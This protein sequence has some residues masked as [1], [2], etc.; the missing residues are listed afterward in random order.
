[1]RARAV[2]GRHHA[3]TTHNAFHTP[4]CRSCA[5]CDCEPTRR[6]EPVRTRSRL[7]SLLQ[8]LRCEHARPCGKIPT[9][10]RLQELRKLRPRT[11]PARRTCQNAVATHVAPTAAS[12][13]PRKP[14]RQS[15]DAHPTAGAAQAATAP[16]PVAANLSERGRDSRRSYSRCDATTQDHAAKFRRTHDCRSCAS[17]DHEPTRRGEPVRTRS[18]LAS[19]LQS[20]RC[21]RVNPCGKIPTHIRLQELRKLRPRTNPSRRT[22]QNVVATHVA[23]T[24][25]AMRPRKTMRQNS[26]AHPTVGAA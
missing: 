1:M 2:S 13:R 25:A 15:S 10:I 4:N 22:C 12:M 21:G 19:L 3:Q 11:N 20:L 24:V 7:T 16:P 26:D 18:R 23:P 6:G 8:S 9:H 17:C 5:S 14:M